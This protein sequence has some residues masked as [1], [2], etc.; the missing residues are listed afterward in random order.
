MIE[1]TEIKTAAFAR[2]FA[3]HPEHL[4]AIVR[5]HQE[6]LGASRF[7]KFE[8]IYRHLLGREL[9]DGESTELG[10]RFSDLVL[11]STVTCPLVPGVLDVLTS[12][13]ARRPLFVASGTPDDELRLIV[14]RRGLERFFVEVHGSPPAKTRL[15]GELI[16]RHRLRPESVL[17]VGDGRSDQRAAEANGLAFLARDSGT[18]EW[19]PGTAVLRDFRQ[20]RPRV[21]P[22]PEGSR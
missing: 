18:Q 12:L 1:S 8:W 5:H 2:L 17:M 20:T 13:A 22:G 9:S 4:D 16:A 7:E 10:R 11:E 14:R 19:P 6:N 3:D 21:V 15:V